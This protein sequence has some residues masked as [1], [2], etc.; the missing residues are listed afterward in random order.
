MK[1]TLLSHPTFLEKEAYLINTLFKMGLTYFHLRKPV[2]TKQE[3]EAFIHEIEPEFRTKIVLHFH[4]RLAEKYDAGVHFH[5]ECPANIDK[6]RQKNHKSTYVNNAFEIP[7]VDYRMDDLVLGPAFNAHYSA[8]H[9]YR[10]QNFDILELKKGTHPNSKIIALGGIT[11]QNAEV[12]FDKGFD[13]IMLYSNL[14]DTYFQS[15][16]ENFFCDFMAYKRAIRL[17]TADDMIGHS[18]F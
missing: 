16:A 17:E 6:M 4:H 7:K 9:A 18:L 8:G 1:V 11:V 3:T 10:F 2:A 13:G 15:G 12:C 14:W 5:E